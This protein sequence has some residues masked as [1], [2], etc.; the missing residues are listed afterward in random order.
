MS[1]QATP[2]GRSFP[3]SPAA[4]SRLALALSV[5]SL[6]VALVPRC[7]PSGEVEPRRGARDP[8]ARGATVE[9]ARREDALAADVAALRKEVAAL[10][11]PAQR[12]ALGPD[13]YPPPA[14]G[15]GRDFQERRALL[16][17]FQ[18]MES[19]DRR[20]A[21]G[22]L[23]ELARWGDAEALAVIE[24]S[25]SDPS[26]SVRV[27]ALEELLELDEPNRMT[28]LRDALNDSSHRVRA[29]VAS[30]LDDLPADQ[31]GPLLVGMLRDADRD[32]VTEAIESLGELE[33]AQAR[34]HLID[35]L[36]A[37]SLDVATSAA[38]A[39]MKLGDE[40]A[41]AGTI[42]R[43][44][45]DFAGEDVSGRVK[46]V[47]RLRRLHATG[48]LE[49]ILATDPSVSVREEARDALADLGE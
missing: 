20:D 22:R 36:G 15:A 33:Y 6:A 4:T 47:K 10:A 26:A 34:P 9:S 21:L 23:A 7:T 12:D 35:Q 39:L 40:G 16:S 24:R 25:L 17:G 8:E 2:S 44:L 5:A 31:A 28:H 46:N 30:H 37:A 27:R 32:V 49:N 1:S 41:A 13:G 11:A 29:A 45:A 43:I 18:G 19:G 38:R 42:Q 3:V 48:P 14:A